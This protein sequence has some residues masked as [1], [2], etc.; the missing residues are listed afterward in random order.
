MFEMH[1]KNIRSLQKS[2]HAFLEFE[3]ILAVRE[4]IRLI[5]SLVDS[6]FS[7]EI[8]IKWLLFAGTNWE[9][10]ASH[11]SPLCRSKI[12]TEAHDRCENVGRDA[13]AIFANRVF[14]NSASR[15]SRR[16]RRGCRFACRII[17]RASPNFQQHNANMHLHVVVDRSLDAAATRFSRP[18]ATS[19][20]TG[21][22]MR[23][24]HTVARAEYSRASEWYVRNET[25]ASVPLLTR[26]GH[27]VSVYAAEHAG[28]ETIQR[29]VSLHRASIFRRRE[30]IS[31]A[32]GEEWFQ[33]LISL[34][35]TLCVFFF[36]RSE[37]YIGNKLA[38]S[39]FRIF[40]KCEKNWGEFGALTGHV[41]TDSRSFVK[42]HIQ[43]EKLPIKS[44]ARRK[45][46]LDP[47]VALHV[48]ARATARTYVTI[49]DGEMHFDSACTRDICRACD[50]TTEY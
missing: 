25:A 11:N 24:R 35:V 18:R 47:R 10:V 4:R 14:A 23:T 33:E 20:V 1:S 28:N 29:F 3:R 6:Q 45:N 49:P 16:G 32:Y 2:T 5:P 46:S 8:K 7:R 42:S 44:T 48:N 31:S 26:L 12:F 19:P 30:H 17:S 15:R 41:S 36:W 13:T 37:I 50:D 27:S 40:V 38:N 39:L 9:I 22:I 21:Y 34:D 43:F